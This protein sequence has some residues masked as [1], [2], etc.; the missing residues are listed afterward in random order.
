[1]LSSAHGW[2]NDLVI[3]V[4]RIPVA[5]S[6]QPA[7]FDR[8]PKVSRAKVPRPGAPRVYP[9]RGKPSLRT[10]RR[11]DLESRD[12]S[13]PVIIGA[14]I[15]LCYQAAPKKSEQI[16]RRNRNDANGRRVMF[17]N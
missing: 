10:D 14:L 6:K 1:M 11:R 16:C 7:R 2:S 17:V 13:R 12:A 9:G 5:H 3:C 15:V 4:C 8:P